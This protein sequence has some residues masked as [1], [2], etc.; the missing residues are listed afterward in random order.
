M[1]CYQKINESHATLYILILLY[2]LPYILLFVTHYICIIPTLTC[3]GNSP[4]KLILCSVYIL[5]CYYHSFHFLSVSFHIYFLWLTQKINKAV[6]LANVLA[7]L[8]RLQTT[9]LGLSLFQ[10]PVFCLLLLRA[11]SSSGLSKYLCS[12]YFIF[13]VYVLLSLFR[14]FVFLLLSCRHLQT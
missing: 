10:F 4:S 5:T 7:V 6:F 12:Y 2:S 13:I 3:S 1:L 11:A 14:S 9:I 8:F